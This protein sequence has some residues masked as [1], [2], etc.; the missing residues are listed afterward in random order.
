MKRLLGCIAA[1]F[2]FSLPISLQAEA[3]CDA[4]K[5]KEGIQAE[6][7]TLEKNPVSAFRAIISLAIS[8]VFDCEDEG[9][10]FS[11][12]AGAQPVLG[13]LAV[14]EGLH[15]ITLTTEGSAR[16]DGVALEGCGNDLDAVILSFEAGQALRGAANLVKVEGDCVLYLEL[17]RITAPWTLTITRAP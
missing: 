12:V 7:D 15:I 17:S 2:I 14:S 9:H 10:S 1:A 13:P 11:D 6:L 4:A 3:A 5:L 8:G 16:V